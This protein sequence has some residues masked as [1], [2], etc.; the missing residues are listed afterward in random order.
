MNPSVMK[1]FPEFRISILRNFTLDP[2][3]P[4]L[5]VEAA[6]AGLKPVIQLGEFDSI[7]QEA[8]NPGSLLYSHQP[9]LIVLAQWLEALSPRFVHEWLTLSSEARIKE[10]VQIVEQLRANLRSIRALSSAPVLVN[11][12]PVLPTF[13][14]GI[15]DSQLENHQ[16]DSHLDLNRQI[17]RVAREFRDVYVV[18]YFKLAAQWGAQN[19][20]DERYW[21]MNRAPLAAKALLPLGREYGSFFRALTGKSRKCLVLDCDNTLWGGI[22]GE[23]GLEGIK[24]GS[25]YP[26]SA[27]LAFQKEILNLRSRGVILALCSKNNEADVLQAL[28]SHPEILLKPE[29]FVTWQVNWENKAS[30]LEKIAKSLNIGLDSLVFVDDSAFECDLV[31]EKL[32]TVSVL[33]LIGDPSSFRSQLIAGAYFDSL[34]FTDEDRKKTE[35]YQSQMKLQEEL[36]E[37]SAGS[38]SLESYLMTLGL[39]VSLWKATKLDQ[40]RVAQLTQKTNQ[41]NLTTLRYTEGAIEALSVDSNAGVF[42]MRVKDRA[43]DYGLVGAAILKFGPGGTDAEIDT[44]LM[45]CRVLGRGVEQAFLAFLVEQAFSR[46]GVEQLVGR[47]IPTQK[48]GQVAQFFPQNGFS[49]FES[50]AR[51]QKASTWAFSK[52]DEHRKGLVWPKWIKRSD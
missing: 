4:V 51:D 41:F 42:C 19:F 35:L 31:R 17:L 28:K 12:F 13:T 45:S 23:D 3:I 29:H 27:F 33:Q 49:P 36:A 32:P 38:E 7:S 14:L 50:A 30:N 10:A 11:N 5:N 26:G 39:E 44:F 25:T 43:T 47:Y 15:L 18:D 1:D 16:L 46:G 22:L 8:R 9:N 20:F 40:P 2:L 48:N 21:Q 52:K 37:A 6:L 34:V 24:L